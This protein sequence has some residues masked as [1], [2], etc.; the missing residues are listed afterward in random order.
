[1]LPSTPL[2]GVLMQDL[3]S[4]VV[5]TSGNRTDEPICIA[6]REAVARLGAIADG[7][8]VHDRPIARHCDDS[9]VRVVRGQELVL[10]RARGYAPLPVRCAP[11]EASAPPILAVGGHLKNT[12]ALT[13]GG[14][15]FVSQHIGDLD[16]PEACAA[17]ERVVADL[18]RLYDVRPAAVAHDLHPDYSSTRWVERN[19]PGIPRI[20]VQH[21]HAHLASCLAENEVAGPALGVTWDGTGYGLDGTVW[22]GEFLLGDAAEVRRV[23]SLRPFRLPGGERAVEEP[24]RSALGLL[25]A[26]L[27]DELWQTGAELAC[28][29]SFAAGERPVLARMLCR[30]LNSPVTSSA[31]RLFDAVAALLGIRQRSGF[32]GQAA[33]EVEHVTDEAEAGAYPVHVRGGG[34]LLIVDW[35]PMLRTLLQDLSGGV[36]LGRIAG[37]FHNALAA[38]IVEVATE[39][40]CRRVALTGGVFQNRILS[41]RA[42]ER[43]GR[44]GFRVYTHQRIPPNDGGISLGQAAVAA[45]RLA[46][47]EGG[48]SVLGRAG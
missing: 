36:P 8:L 42:A 15:A 19:L 21:H 22:G 40:G 38:A 9:V 31:G 34:P 16:S 17:F 3:G 43:L 25:F 12:V 14:Q 24:R 26:M 37:R 10:R 35:E 33:M 46:R 5:A 45:T 41:E 2:H 29:R 47:V 18:L 39:I 44:A 4:P 11:V 32:E 7:F 28:V 27:G 1:M 48:C 13:V 6:E 23:A 30:G 20:P